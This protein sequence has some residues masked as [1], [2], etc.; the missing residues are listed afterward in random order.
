MTKRREACGASGVA[1]EESVA[2][3]RSA[4][5]S[6]ATASRTAQPPE[7]SHAPRPRM[8]ERF[9]MTVCGYGALFIKSTAA[10]DPVASVALRGRE[11]CFD[12]TSQLG[13]LHGV[14]WPQLGRVTISFPCSRSD[15]ASPA[16]C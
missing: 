3:T 8:S 15:P 10:R 5:S 2:P 14:P 7:S 1:P 12:Q 11:S 13:W 4:T 16:H 6:R 9:A